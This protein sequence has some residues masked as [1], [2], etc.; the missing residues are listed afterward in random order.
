LR[1]LAES[2]FLKMKKTLLIVSVACLAMVSCKKNYTCEC[3]QT[4]VGAA[5]RVGDV[6]INDTKSG[7]KKQCDVLTATGGDGFSCM[8]K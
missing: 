6:T 7:A 1:T 4:Q 2:M 3:T 8:I 5:P